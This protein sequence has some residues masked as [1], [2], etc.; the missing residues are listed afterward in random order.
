MVVF[1][2]IAYLVQQFSVVLMEK[3]LNLEVSF[4]EYVL[5]KQ[6]VPVVLLYSGVIV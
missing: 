1:T 2:V 6:N 5:D 4:E 3:L